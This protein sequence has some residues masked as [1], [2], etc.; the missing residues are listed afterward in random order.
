MSTKLETVGKV[1]IKAYCDPTQENMGLENYGYVV[2][3][4]HFK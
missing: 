4:T 2:S 3:Q 1:S